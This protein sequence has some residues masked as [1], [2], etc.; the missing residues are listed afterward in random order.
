MEDLL[1]SVST[2]YK[3]DKQEDAFLT[4]VSA[5]L[6]K[7]RPIQSS[8]PAPSTPDEA[9]E[10][11]KSKP[12]LSSLA[13]VLKYFVEATDINLHLPSPLGSQIIN[14]L[15]SNIV[16]N[17]W[18]LL[19]E[20]KKGKG[21]WSHI[22]ERSRLLEVLR[23]ISGLGAIVAKLKA[24]LEEN[25][26]TAKKVDGL[27]ISTVIKDYIELLGAILEDEETLR[28]LHSTLSN[29][30]R[31]LQQAL[32]QELVALVGGGRVLSVAAEAQNVLKEASKDVDNSAWIAD[33]S[34]YSTW[35][36][37]NL[38]TWASQLSMSGDEGAWDALSAM[39]RK[40]MRLG[41]PGKLALFSL[42]P[43]NG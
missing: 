17:Y 20:R 25:R 2:A 16:P 12:D 14:V 22:K 37:K 21:G 6:P 29:G 35:I 8:I 28:N 3:A 10:A 42:K 38:T 40:S 15:V 19:S 26:R 18:S 13:N 4:E 31:S 7:I 5:P 41:Y 33:P 1:N 32:W 34:R 30:P 39:L 9:L 43:R 11:L 23:N 24:L 27:N 36:G